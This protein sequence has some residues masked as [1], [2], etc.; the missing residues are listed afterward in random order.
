VQ[1][2]GG[3]QGLQLLV[4]VGDF[5]ETLLVHIPLV[6]LL[7]LVACLQAFPGGCLLEGNT[8]NLPM[9]GLSAK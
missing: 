2:L 9:E 5:D 8:G 3:T 1:D 4:V 7:L 6:V